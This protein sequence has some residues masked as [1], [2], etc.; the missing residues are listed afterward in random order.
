[1]TKSMCGLSVAV[2]VC[3]GFATAASA[4]NITSTKAPSPKRVAKYDKD[5]VMLE[6]AGPTDAGAAA[7]FQKA[8]ASCGLQAKIQE[9]KKGGKQLQVIAAVDRTMDLGLFGKAVMTALPTK[10]GQMPPG[11]ELLIYAPLTKESSEHAMA[12]LEEVK[13]V[14]AK[15]SSVDVKKGEL[16]VRISGAERVTAEEIL[17]AVEAAGVVPKLAK[18]GHVKKA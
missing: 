2:A 17:R 16:R 13:G 3:L 10:P 9:S 1:M 8:L 14:D 15:H 7:A 6:I 5:R 18:E 12:Q 11:L 4:K